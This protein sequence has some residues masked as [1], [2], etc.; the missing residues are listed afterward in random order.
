MAVHTD[1][2]SFLHLN[3]VRVAIQCHYIQAHVL[4]HVYCNLLHHNKIKVH[5][6]DVG[7][8]HELA[9]MLGHC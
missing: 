8:W 5:M 9:R 7:V 2:T 6:S 4:L 1:Y 3:I